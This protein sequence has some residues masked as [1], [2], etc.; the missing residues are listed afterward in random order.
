MDKQDRPAKE[1]R[2]YPTMKNCMLFNNLVYIDDVLTKHQEAVICGVYQLLA[3][4]YYLGYKSAFTILNMNTADIINPD[5]QVLF[6][7]WWSLGLM[8]RDSGM[9]VGYWTFS[10]KK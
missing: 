6:L 4:K 8:W 10:N 9:N 5:A 2:M 3:S 7:S 1:P